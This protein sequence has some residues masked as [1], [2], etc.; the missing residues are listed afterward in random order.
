MTFFL[1][2]PVSPSRT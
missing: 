2:L 1:T